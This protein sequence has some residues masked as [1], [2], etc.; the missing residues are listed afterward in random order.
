MKAKA[1]TKLVRN[2]LTPQ[3]VTPVRMVDL[4]MTEAEYNELQ[5]L[6]RIKKGN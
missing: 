6:I 1:Y 4:T 2:P 5:K 3:V